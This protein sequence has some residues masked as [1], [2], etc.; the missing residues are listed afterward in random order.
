MI[1]HDIPSLAAL[2]AFEAAVRTGSLSAAARELNVTHAA[3][4]QHVRTLEDHLGVSLLARAGRKMAPTAEGSALAQSLSEGFGQIAAGVRAVSAAQQDKPVSLTLTPS[5][6]E[7]WLMP[8]LPDFWATHPEITLSIAPSTRLTDLRA[9]GYDLGIRYGKGQ[10][11]GLHAEF[12]LSA[13]YVIAASPELLQG[14]EACC[15]EDLKDFTWVFDPTIKEP[16]RWA[17]SNGLPIC[18]TKV[19]ELGTTM[20]IL[21]A[22]RASAGIAI[23]PEALVQ[24]DIARGT[25][26]EVLDVVGVEMG[27]YIVT[28]SAVP[29]PR[30]RT[31]IKWLKRQASMGQN[32]PTGPASALSASKAKA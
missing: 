32:A 19:M 3:I 11:P 17:E 9:D 31:L 6:A 4:A 26:R 22:V 24:D 5:V 8:R 28:P 23:L 16:R 30:V 14:K 13:N 18:D 29:P 25:L 2:R 12:L 21:S 10:W 15:L 27:Y 1:W 7:Q 20:M